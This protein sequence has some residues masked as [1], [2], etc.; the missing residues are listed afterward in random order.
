MAASLCS[1]GGGLG[2]LRGGAGACL[3]RRRGAG[4]ELLARGLGVHARAVLGV[5]RRCLGRAVDVVGGRHARRAARPSG[6]HDRASARP[7]RRGSSPRPRRCPSRSAA[8]RG[9]RSR[10]SGRSRPSPCSAL[11]SSGVNARSACWTRLPSWPRTSAGT[12][13]GVWVT[14]N[15]P[16]PLERISRT[17][18]STESTN[19]LRRA[20]E[21]QVR[22]V[23]EEDELGLVE[24]ADLGQRLEQLGQQPH[25]RGR[26]QLGLVLHR[27]QLE[28][29]DDP[30]AVGRGAQQVGDVE[31]RLAEE[32]VAAA[33]L[34]P[35]Q[36]AQQHADGLASTA[37]RCPRA[38]PCRRRSPGRSAARAGRRGPAAAGPSR[39]RSGRRAAGSAPGSRWTPSTLASSCGPKSETV[40]RTGTPGPMPPSDRNSTGKAVGVYSMPSSAGALGRDARRRR[41]RAARPE[42]SPLMSA[43]NDRHAGRRE[44]LGD[45]LQ[46]LGLAGAGRAGD[47]AVAVHHRQR[48]LDDRLAGRARP[49]ARRGRVSSAG[50]S[51]A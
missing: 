43:T 28:A 14:K 36:R 39:R 35:D 12:S 24:V 49:R 6:V 45:A 40:A 1:F 21:Q 11:A 13:F 9:R 20:V 2:R 7:S 30:A 37:R 48:D 26:E 44:L 17:V 50:P 16:T 5:Q 15:T 33:V 47:Q 32:L 18:C 51:V 31:L 25:Q 29:R 46:R 3:G 10:T 42:T 38:R 41:P 34:Q 23:E 8:R 4:G 19:A 27:G 22:L